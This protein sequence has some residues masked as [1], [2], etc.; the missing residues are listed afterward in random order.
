VPSPT[1]LAIRQEEGYAELSGYLARTDRS[2]TARPTSVALH[3][4]AGAR[5][6]TRRAG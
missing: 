5:G 3:T 4:I 2:M 1:R 6:Y